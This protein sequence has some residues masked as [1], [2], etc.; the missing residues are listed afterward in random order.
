MSVNIEGLLSKLDDKSLID[1]INKYDV[2]CILESFITDIKVLENIFNNCSFYF[3]N[4]KKLSHQGRPSGGVLVL[5]KNHLVHK[6]NV[7]EVNHVFD[8]IVCLRFDFKSLGADVDNLLLIAAYLPPY[9]SPYYNSSNYESGIDLLEHF[10]IFITEKIPDANIILCGDLN[11]RISNLQPISESD[12]IDKYVD[13]NNNTLCFDYDCYDRCSQDKEVNIYGRGLFDL[14]VIYDLIVLN[15]FCQSDSLGAFTYVSK[16]GSSVIDFFIVST[17]FLNYDIDM[18]VINSSFSCHLP[19]VLS[20][21]FKAPIVNSDVDIGTKFMTYEKIVWNDELTD[22]FINNVENI[23]SDNVL[24][25]IISSIDVNVNHTVDLISCNL[26]KA[27]AIFMKSFSVNNNM[28][29]Y[30]NAWYDKECFNAKKKVNSCLR[31]FNRH[32]T[33]E[34]KNIYLDERNRYKTLLRRKKYLFTID[35]VNIISHKA[36]T[37][38][39]QF[40]SELR[41]LLNKSTKCV[42]NI[43]NNEWFDYFKMYF[44]INASVPSLVNENYCV[45]VHDEEMCDMLNSPITTQEVLDVINS[46]KCNKACGPDNILNEMLYFS[47]EKLLT[48]FVSLFSFIFN[49]H[50]RISSWQKSLISPILKKGNINLCTNYR[51]I[52]L[53]SLFLKMFTSILNN[54]LKVYT[55][56]LSIIP[57]EQAAFRKD[58]S[59]IDHIFSLYTLIIKQF[60]Q[61]R[62]LYVCFIDYSRCFD[63]IHREALFTMLKRN[64]INGNFLEMLKSLYDNVSS[65]VKCA[66]NNF[67]EYFDCP[68]GLKQGCILSPI[69]FNIFISEVSRSINKNGMHGIQLVP[70]L[71]IFHHLFYAD[72]NCIFSTT[73]MGLQNKLNIIHEQSK[74]L[75][76]TVNINKTKIMVFRKGGHLSRHE[77]WFY[78]N[79]P[80][81]VVNNYSYLGFT[82]TTRLSFVNSSTTLIAKAK[83][84]TNEILFSLKKLSNFDIN[85]FTKLFDSKVL[86]ILSYGCELWGTSDIVNIERVHLYSLKRFLNISIHSSNNK[87]YSETGRYPLH[88]NYKLR[89]VKYWL[90]IKS[91]SNDRI[92][93]QSYECLLKLCSK[94][95]QNWVSSVQ[96]VLCSNGFGV[97]WLFGEIGDKN[98]FFSNLK[99][100]L[101]DNFIQNWNSKLNSD[102]HC[103]FYFGL[104]PVIETELYLRNHNLKLHLR[105]ILVKFRLGVTEIYCHRYKFATNDILKQCPFCIRYHLENEIHLLFYCPLYDKFRL[106]YFNNL[107]NNLIMN[108]N[109]VHDLFVHKW[110]IVSKYL[111]ECFAYRKQIL[112]AR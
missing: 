98:K 13:Q 17:P 53:S 64:G 71:D 59:T 50:S 40:W 62:K 51:P 77:K 1:T 65:A 94:G 74:R 5:I 111:Y 31:N 85:L 34:N 29:D 57:K 55:E 106:K 86:P 63:G 38:Q 37:S 46:L 90:K 15:G 44:Q 56:S 36:N 79:T 91:H 14:C 89:C 48:T 99:Q 35:K 47:S 22:E 52:T 30:K 41:S 68:V 69:L 73:P 110:Y 3:K 95:N 12:I 6:L 27:S 82:F 24:D 42:N 26:L 84:A 32:N 23:F 112:N 39:Q 66:N 2:V 78:G 93:K 92:V 102:I 43:S 103:T 33:Y 60:A 7:V 4:A 20:L 108:Q 18:E 76:L 97:V 96:N 107:D 54:R 10:M 49:S 61:N 87:V 80:L 104:K 16:Q 11:S 19:V 28:I 101:I 8:N 45:Y 21:N 109:T 88:I 25:N 72:D 105:N 83:K 81:E 58:Y 9:S 75:G 70:N 67:T 100:T